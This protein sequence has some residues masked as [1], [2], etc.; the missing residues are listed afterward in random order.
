VAVRSVDVDAGDDDGVL[1]HIVVVIVTAIAIITSYD[2]YKSSRFLQ[3]QQKW[4][5][6]AVVKVATVVNNPRSR[7]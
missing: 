3:K 1:R 6:M 2:Q 7:E 4:S 5:K